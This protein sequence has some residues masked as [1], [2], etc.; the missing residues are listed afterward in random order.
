MNVMNKVKDAIRGWLNIEAAQKRDYTIDETF[1]FE[2]NAI[3]NRI[4][5]RGDPEEL[6][7]FYKQLERDYSYFWSASPR[8]KIRK[9]HSGLPALMVQ[10]LTDIVIRDLNGITMES[11][12]VDWDEIAR[13]NNFNEVL[14]K[15]VKEA[16]FIGDGA[17]KLS[18]DRSLSQYPI[19]EFIPGDKVEIIYK[20]GRFQECVFKTEY[21]HNQKRYALYEHY[22]YG[23]IKNV[24]TEWGQN[25]P[26]PLDRIPQT[27]MLSDLG[28]GGYSETE[29]G[30]INGRFCMAV[31][32]K[33]K[34]ST[35]WEYRGESIFDK[36][37]SSFDGFDEIISQWSDAVRAARAK[38][39]IPETLIPR[40][41]STGEMLNFNQYD[42]RFLMIEG[43]MKEGNQ[44]QINVTQPIIPSE[45]YLQSYI[46]F[47]DLCLQG[48]LSPSTLGIDTKKMDNAEAQREKEKTT[49]YTRNIIIEA[50]QKTLPALLNSVIKAYDEYTKK[51]SGDDEE[52]TIDFGEYASP[53]FE[54]TVETV[55]KARPGKVIMSIEASV[56]EMYGDSKDDDWKAEEVRRLRM[57]NGF[58]ETQEPTI[59]EFDDLG[60]TAPTQDDYKQ[61]DE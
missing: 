48:I 34:D 59:G 46:T 49:L 3:K 1:N 53:S 35:K 20:R 55:S 17:F 9:I 44:G 6:E 21:K 56:D 2:T 15:A 11:R 38:Q 50:I 23:Y 27:A 31:P 16:L 36:K 32:F 43:A 51:S 40:D 39:Y 13:D 12:Q 14:R 52:V 28:F 10:V 7:Q 5:M 18:F 8:I 24:L 60:G 22:G 45:N 58:M 47:L 37:T 30:I 33:I 4:W 41:P 29:Q 57:E 61:D 25:D 42:D 26:L 54:A 19:I